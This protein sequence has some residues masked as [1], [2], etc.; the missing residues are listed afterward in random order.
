M[1]EIQ[2]AYNALAGIMKREAD[3]Q[4]TAVD[5]LRSGPI[6]I[7]KELEWTHFVQKDP[8]FVSADTAIRNVADIEYPGR[9][10]PAA[11]EVRAGMLERKSKY[12]KSY[13]P[14]WYV[15]LSFLSMA[16]NL[17]FAGMCFRL[18]ICTNLNL[19][20]ASTRNHRSC[21]C[22]FQI[23]SWARTRSLAQALTSLCSRVGKL[24]QCTVVVIHGSFAPSPTT[25]W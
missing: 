21:H 5:Q 24:A 25:P 2:K 7:P 12:L 19:Q 14:G 18:L 23:R 22:C 10:H 17:H 15:L 6:T 13:T 1:G 16:R 4:Y 20:I 8:H 3:E 11:A 9:N